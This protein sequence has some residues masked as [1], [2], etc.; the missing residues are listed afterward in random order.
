[1]ALHQEGKHPQ[2]VLRSTRRVVPVVVRDL[3]R[4]AKTPGKNLRT[5]GA[6][7]LK[8]TVRGN[9]PTPTLATSPS[10]FTG[11]RRL[12]R[13]CN[14]QTTNGHESVSLR[15]A[16]GCRCELA[17][18]RMLFV[19]GALRRTGQGLP[20]VVAGERLVS[21]LRAPLTVPSPQARSFRLSGRFCSTLALCGLPA[22]AARF[23]HSL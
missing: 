14:K 19:K 23:R 21:L 16:N 13:A 5:A 8:A 15:C 2:P 6:M 7:F 10:A 17:P 1:M 4:H 9:L 18:R 3:C 20:T 12:S 11:H 22:M